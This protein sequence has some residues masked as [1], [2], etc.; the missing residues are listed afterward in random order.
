MW[1]GGFMAVVREME[2]EQY[3][4]FLDEVIKRCNHFTI[5]MLE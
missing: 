5:K 1:L 3:T 4:F 2:V